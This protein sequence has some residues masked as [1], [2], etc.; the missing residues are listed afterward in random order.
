MKK[1]QRTTRPELEDIDCQIECRKEYMWL[2]TSDKVSTCL[3]Y[4]EGCKTCPI[5]ISRVRERQIAVEMARGR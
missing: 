4:P 2:V 5:G 3:T 1:A